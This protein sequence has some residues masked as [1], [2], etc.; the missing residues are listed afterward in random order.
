MPSDDGITSC[1]ADV[2]DAS[3][4]RLFSFTTSKD[5]LFLKSG[6]RKFPAFDELIGTI[7]PSTIDGSA[8]VV[9]CRDE[10]ID[11]LLSG[12]DVE[13]GVDVIPIDTV[14]T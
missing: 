14:V 1:G 13:G 5:L 7:K 12:L 8:V 3:N 2:E 4:G 6:I 10:R 9:D 11:E